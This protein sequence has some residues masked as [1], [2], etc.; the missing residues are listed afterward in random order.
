MILVLAGLT[1]NTPTAI[2]MLAIQLV[3]QQVENNVLYPVI[4]RRAVALSPLTTVLAVMIGA[5]L[6]G[7]IGAIVAVPLAAIIKI[8][9]HEAALPRRTRMHHLRQPRLADTPD[10]VAPPAP[11]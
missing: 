8:V 10:E 2:A 9:V 11:R 4:F 7:V 5:S 6:L 3:Y 1:I